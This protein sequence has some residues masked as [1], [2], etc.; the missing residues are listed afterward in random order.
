MPS[1]APAVFESRLLDRSEVMALLK[2]SKST[3]YNLINR[4]VNPLPSV[5]IGKSRRFPND[6][7]HYWMEMLGR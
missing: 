2:I 3:L 4:K 6:K 7:I 5:V 1:T